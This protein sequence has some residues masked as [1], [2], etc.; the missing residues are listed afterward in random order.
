[1]AD[2][3]FLMRMPMDGRDNLH[4]KFMGQIRGAQRL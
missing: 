4:A 2:I 3:L 1:M